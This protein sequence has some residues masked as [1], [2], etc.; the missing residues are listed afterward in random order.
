[1][2]PQHSLETSSR[3]AHSPGLQEAPQQIPEGRSPPPSR[4]L[5]LINEAELF[6]RAGADG[7]G[8]AERPRRQQDSQ[9]AKSCPT[10]E[11]SCQWPWTCKRAGGASCG[12]PSVAF[13]SA[14][15]GAPAIQRLQRLLGAR[16]PRQTGLSFPWCL[17][18]VLGARLVPGACSAWGGVV[19]G[20]RG[21]SG[22]M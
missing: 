7:G 4:S 22:K 3:T 9:G 5:A 1:M 12:G 14:E 16:A 17:N 10:R 21:G 8:G 13:G 18:W 11:G 6:D 15:P 2:P 19:G 20:G